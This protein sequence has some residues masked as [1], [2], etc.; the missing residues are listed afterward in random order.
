MSEQRNESLCQQVEERIASVIEGDVE[1]ELIEHIAGCDRCRDLRHDATLAARA[2]ADADGDYAHPADFEARVMRALDAR[3]AATAEPKHEARPQGEPAVEPP[4]AEPPAAAA[5]V[6]PPVA[7]EPAAKPAPEPEAPEPVAAEPAAKP[8]PEPEAPKPVAAEPAAKPAPEPA[9]P[10]AGARASQRPS[11]AQPLSGRRA[12]VLALG[13]VSVAALASAAVVALHVRSRGSGA[14]GGSGAG[15]PWSGRVAEVTRSA[16]DAT[17]GVEICAADGKGCAPADEGASL[18]PGSLVRTDTRTRAHVELGDGSR[19]AI[20]RG[21]EVAFPSGKE[22]VARLPRGAIVAEVAQVEGA[23]SAKFEMPTGTLEVL[24]TKLALVA[25][26]D[27]ATVEVVRGVV[28]LADR[29]GSTVTVRAGE[30]GMVASGRAPE[31]TVARDLAESVAWSD[32]RGKEPSAEDVAVRGLGELRARKPGQTAERDQAVRLARHDVKIRVV[33]VVARTEVDETFTNDTGEVLEGIYRFPMPA[34]A[35]IERLALEVDG[36]LEDGAF[37]DKDKA[38]AIWRGVIQNAAPLAPKPKEEILWVPGPWRDPAL[39]EWQRGGRFELRIYPIP[40]RGSRR[41]VLAYTQAVPPSGGVRRYTYPL[42]YD[43]AGSTRVGELNVDAQVIGHDASYGV[44]PRGYELAKDSSGGAGAD[45]LRMNARSFAPSGD[46][47]LEYMLPGDKQELTAWAYRP[48][49]GVDAGSAAYVAIALRPKLPRWSEGKERTQVVVVDSSR[50]MV[51]ERFKRG[52]RLAEA[53]VREMD[54]RD[55]FALLACDSACRAMPDDGASPGAAA[56][57]RVR[58]FLGGIEPDGASDL[59]EAVRE[60]KRVGGATSGRELRI[61]Y[62]GDG[63]PSAGPVRPAHITQEI[64]RVLPAGEGMVTAVAVG[65]DADTQTLAALARGGGGVV[66]PYVPGENVSTAAMHVLATSYGMALRSPSVELPDGLTDVYP[67]QLDTIVAGGESFV[68]ARLAAPELSG[69]VKLRGKVGGEAYEQTFPIKVVSSSS[70]GNAF[71]PRQYAAAKISELEVTQGENA[72]T[73]LVELSKRFAV[74]SRY[75]SLLVL[76]SPAM[77]KAFGV[78]RATAAPSWSGEVGTESTG[79]DGDKEYAASGA[80]DERVGFGAGKG[81]LAGS[82]KAPAAD[83]MMDPYAGGGGPGGTRSGVA[84]VSGGGYKDEADS[85][86]EKSAPATAAGESVAGPMGQMAQPPAPAAPPPAAT[87][88]APAKRAAEPSR[89][90]IACQPG[91]P[92]C[93]VWDSPPP[94]RPPRDRWGRNM[95]PMRRVWDRKANI[96]GD[97]AS[98]RGAVAS[99][100][101]GLEGELAA[102]PDSRTKLE[103]LLGLYQVSGQVERAAELA[104]RWSGRDALDPGALVARAMLA[105]REGDRARALRTLGGLA[106]LRPADPATQNWIASAHEALGDSRRA[107]EHRIALAEV[108]SGD[109]AAVAGAVRCA[110]ATGSSAL[111]DAL[112][113]SVTKDTV[114]TAIDRE[115]AKTTDAALKG[116]VQVEASWGADVDLDVALIGKNGERFSALGDAKG[117]VTSRAAASPRTEALAVVNAPAG[118]YV[119]EVTRAS[120]SELQPPASGTLVVRAAGTTRTIPFTLIGKRVEAGSIKIYYQ[121]RL[122]PVGW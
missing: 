62:L 91:D 47:T 18:R 28:R 95:V 6:A 59:L 42:S 39:L 10:T 116:D 27:R 84:S 93:G 46:L 71:V 56:A 32:R 118:D 113:T 67:R 20:D 35:Q 26:E 114:R 4:A 92:M 117:R 104:A 102:N 72:K 110:R 43:P 74:A 80:D 1:P 83:M 68:V 21:T 97:A 58:E 99:K 40:A 3:P 94:P 31:V 11:S 2:V 96:F 103:S 49:T 9:R 51:G 15:D 53:I 106:D 98:V 75:T 54:K 69:T 76:E 19:I 14:L 77:F 33:D 7:A 109:A 63:A 70:E 111:A 120:A 50:S 64:A 29:G 34:D 5:V 48:S 105:A 85:R 17:G 36:K 81:R 61:V 52:A 101:V 41:V 89:N 65:S 57:Q 45:R 86:R 78:E 82:H 24:G 122:V 88:T 8:A 87:A 115:L 60:A 107:C 38:A 66:I 55:R 121:D 108:R 25:S 112:L 30:E 13:V 73:E 37:V 22:R 79:S 16:K 100:L 23:P 44:R 119:I 12:K 90:P